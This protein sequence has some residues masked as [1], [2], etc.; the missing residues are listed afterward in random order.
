M[1]G[2]TPLKKIDRHVLSGK[3]R[4]SVC[5]EPKPDTLNFWWIW[6]TCLKVKKNE[7]N[8]RVAFSWI[9]STL[10]LTQHFFSLTAVNFLFLRKNCLTAAAAAN[11]SSYLGFPFFQYNLTHAHT[12][13]GHQDTSSIVQLLLLLLKTIC[14]SLEAL[15]WQWYL[16]AVNLA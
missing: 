8:C 1:C 11:S 9:F 5:W 12:H 6:H 13:F 14:C 15:V 10:P 3:S 2:L 4:F 7:K 16:A